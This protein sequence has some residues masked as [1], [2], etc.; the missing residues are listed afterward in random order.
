LICEIE[1][2]LISD[3]KFASFLTDFKGLNVALEDAYNEY[4]DNLN[5]YKEA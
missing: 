4:K 3:T 5:G 2:H 1:G